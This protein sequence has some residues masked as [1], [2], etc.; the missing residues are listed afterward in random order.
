M[1]LSGHCL[2]NSN[3]HCSW[4]VSCPLAFLEYCSLH[5]DWY[6]GM[7]SS[8][9]GI[10]WVRLLFWIVT[11]AKLDSGLFNHLCCNHHMDP[12]NP[13]IVDHL[14][15]SEEAGEF[16]SADFNCFDCRINCWPRSQS[17]LQDFSEIWTESR[18][19]C[20]L[21]LWAIAV[22]QVMTF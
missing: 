11:K 21:V 5:S 13:G 3:G 22:W 17:S 15:A 8:L 14:E 20:D 7:N 6:C 1:I 16:F 10:C 9:T 12:K 19:V 18:E 4:I 2:M